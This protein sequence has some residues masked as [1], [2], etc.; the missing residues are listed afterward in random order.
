MAVWASFVTYWPYNLG[1]TLRHYNFEVADSSGWQP[2][3][4]SLKVA[5]L[6]AAIGTMVIFFGA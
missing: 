4:N 5:A 3:F 2:F 1:L 6:T